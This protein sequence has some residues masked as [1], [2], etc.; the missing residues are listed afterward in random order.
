[1]STTSKRIAPSCP[2]NKRSRN[3]SGP[4][5]KKP[6]SPALRPQKNGVSTTARLSHGNKVAATPQAFTS[7]SSKPSSTKQGSDAVTVTFT[8][9]LEKS[10]R[11]IAE[12]GKITIDSF[13]TDTVENL[14]NQIEGDDSF[15]EFVA[16]AWNH[17]TMQEA[18]EV[19]RNAIELDGRADN[20]TILRMPS[21]RF[22]AQ[23][24]GC[25]VAEGLRNGGVIVGIVDGFTGSFNSAVK[26]AA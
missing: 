6:V 26:E 18:I 7:K 19:A 10:L 24:A 14:V 17:D 13:V 16:S 15:G 5:A 22:S 12:A 2:K 25:F 23:S 11:A 4:H 9:K 1:M 20:W 8:G 3:G 21:G